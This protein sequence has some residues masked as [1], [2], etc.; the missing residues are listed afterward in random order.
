MVYRCN[1][2]FESLEQGVVVHGQWIYSN[3]TRTIT[4]T[5]HQ[6]KDY[7]SKVVTKIERMSDSTLMIKGRDAEGKAL[8][9]F[10]TVR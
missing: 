2:D 8:T 4:V 3:Q 1:R 9:L 7:P 5:Q 6:T 10:L